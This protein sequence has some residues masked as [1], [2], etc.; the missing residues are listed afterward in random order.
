MTSYYEIAHNNM[1]LLTIKSTNLESTALSHTTVHSVW[2]YF[3]IEANYPENVPSIP[4]DIVLIIDVSSSMKID[5]KYITMLNMI[6]YLLTKLN[7]RHTITLITF[8]NE[9][10]VL[11]HLLEC[12][13]DNKT[14]ILSILNKIK[15]TELLETTNI[16]AGLFAG[17]K[18]ILNRPYQIKPSSLLLFTDGNH[19]IGFTNNYLVDELRKT[20]LPTDCIINT[21]GIGPTNNSEL[22]FTIAHLG[23]GC[24]HHIDNTQNNE[25]IVK[26]FAE[27]ITSLLNILIC[28][29][30]IVFKCHDG[31]R[32]ITLV[33]PFEM[34]MKI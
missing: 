32:L 4:L 5:N 27:Y 2:G 20:K 17:I 21:F 19:S 15:D 1:D 31:C 14:K 6:K 33:T 25:Q 24:Y 26:I 29:I 28:N 12:S 16:Y 10:L 13:D 18:I 22:L 7:E 30:K 23:K 3:T 11:T 9:F 8:N 34:E